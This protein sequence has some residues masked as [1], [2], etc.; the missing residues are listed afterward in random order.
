M[1]ELFF[2]TL[3][4]RLVKPYVYEYQAFAKERWY[5]RE[6]FDVLTTE[7]GA[8]TSQYYVGVLKQPRAQR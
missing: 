1:L 6:L 8:Y 5:Q 2:M 7:F 4:Y 3:G